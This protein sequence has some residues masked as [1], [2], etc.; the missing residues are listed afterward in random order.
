MLK[1]VVLFWHICLNS[2]SDQPFEAV[3]L[4]PV[5]EVNWQID[6][7]HYTLRVPVEDFV[8][9]ADWTKLSK[10]CHDTVCAYYFKKCRT[11][12]SGFVCDYSFGN[13]KAEQMLDF[14][15]EIEKMSDLPDIEK[16]IGVWVEG[17][18]PTQPELFL[19]KDFTEVSSAEF[20]ECTSDNP[21]RDCSPP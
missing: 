6:G 16:V 4:H 3:R 11:Y 5:R 1:C 19:L 14:A 12:N 18:Y 15:I 9:A 13:Q 10:A 20:P 17:I 21:E 7:S 8:P 2:S